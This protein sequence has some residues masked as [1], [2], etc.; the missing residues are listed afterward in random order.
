MES[1]LRTA[2]TMPVCTL[3]G[4]VKILKCRMVT[5]MVAGLKLRAMMRRRS[6]TR[7][8]IR[9][10]IVRRLQSAAARRRCA[11]SWPTVWMPRHPRR[12]IVST[13]P[14]SVVKYPKSRGT[15]P[16]TGPWPSP[17]SSRPCQHGC[18]G[19]PAPNE[20]MFHEAIFGIKQYARSLS[21]T[22]KQPQ[23]WGRQDESSHQKQTDRVQKN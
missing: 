8:Q 17:S 1:P 22:A 21:Q 3:I 6:V 10:Q 5:V 12:W 7:G 14:F 16:Q 20:G 4:G 13:K 18:T 15:V 11:H 9:E 23:N 19:H 2:L